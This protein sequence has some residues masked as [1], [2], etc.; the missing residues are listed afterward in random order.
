MSPYSIHLELGAAGTDGAEL[1]SVH[2]ASAGFLASLRNRL[3]RYEGIDAS[4]LVADK[5]G[6]LGILTGFCQQDRATAGS[7]GKG[8][9]TSEDGR[10]SSRAYDRRCDA[11]VSRVFDPSVSSH[12]AHRYPHTAP[13]GS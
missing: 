9:E 5:G 3:G 10:A 2:V 12:P 6:R 8:V 13:S 1:G 4:S 11:Q 7:N